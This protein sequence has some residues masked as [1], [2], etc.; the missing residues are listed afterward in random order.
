MHYLVGLYGVSTRRA[1]RVVQTTRSSVY[2]ISRK[3]LLT[4]L[5]Q[6]MRELA[7]VTCLACFGPAEA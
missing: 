3:D 6:R 7:Q 5:R 2:Y 4:A 1:C